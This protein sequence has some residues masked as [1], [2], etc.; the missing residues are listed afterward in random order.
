MDPIKIFSIIIFACSA[1]FL[2]YTFY[3]KT[4]NIH[5]KAEFLEEINIPGKKTLR[6]IN[7]LNID[8]GET[9]VVPRNITLYNMG[10]IQGAGMGKSAGAGEKRNSPVLSGKGQRTL[11]K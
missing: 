3:P 1:F 6:L 7:G 4:I 9:I 10:R 11:K 8:E 2:I 5:T